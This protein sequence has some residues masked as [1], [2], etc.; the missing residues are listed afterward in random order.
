MTCLLPPGVAWLGLALLAASAMAQDRAGLGIDAPAP[1]LDAFGDPLPQGAVLRLGTTRLRH[2]QGVEGVAFSPDGQLVAS[3]GWDD[4]VRLW[5][6]A[7]GAPVGRLISPQ[8]EGGLGVAFSPDGSQLAATSENGSV[9]LWDVA[10]RKLLWQS[11]SF[12]GGRVY[13]VAFAPDGE[14]LAAACSATAIHLFRV[15]DGRAIREFDTGMEAMDA[16]PLAFSPDGALL[17]SAGQNRSSDVFIWNVGS[18]E[19]V[20][21]IPNAHDRDPVSAIFTG[22]GRQLVT[23][24]VQL[25]QTPE[26]RLR[27]ASDIRVWDVAT[28]QLAGEFPVNDLGH[29]P[30][31]ALSPDE[32]FLYSTHHDRVVTW[33]FADRCPCATSARRGP[34]SAAAPTRWLS[35]PMAGNSPPKATGSDRTKFGSGISRSARRST[36]RPTPTPRAF[37]RWT[38]PPMASSSPPAGPT[39][40]CGSGT[41]RPAR[42]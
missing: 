33:D 32:R 21:R 22:N 38:S 12:G 5:N 37:W 19:V 34:S 7:T 39:S 24:G 4:S 2:M 35:R 20:Q 25:Q 15:A 11:R 42:T 14:T 1:R 17:A 16:R 40:P 27:T 23:S 13:S 26:G 10:E 30:A 8:G 36:P 28:G 29:A 41:P 18:G 3:I 9:R 31:L 6:V